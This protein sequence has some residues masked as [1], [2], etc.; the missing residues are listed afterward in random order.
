MTPFNFWRRLNCPEKPSVGS[1]VDVRREPVVARSLN[2]R[3]QTFP[4]TRK[5]AAPLLEKL[6]ESLGSPEPAVRLIL[7]I[8]IGKFHLVSESQ[9]TS[10]Q[11]RL[12]TLTEQ[13][14]LLCVAVSANVTLG[15]LLTLV[16]WDTLLQ[17]GCMGFFLTHCVNS[18]IL[19]R[20][21]Q[22]L[23]SKNQGINFQKA[24]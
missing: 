6:S 9:P 17:T 21:N 19:F 11:P 22:S 12:T 15:Q 4:P 20:V 16:N 7:S 23:T 24:S 1:G 8:L 18:S 14:W 3:Q 2:R 10:R 5:M 13:L